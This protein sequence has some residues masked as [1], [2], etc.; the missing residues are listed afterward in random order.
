MNLSLQKPQTREVISPL[1]VECQNEAEIFKKVDDVAA[2]IKSDLN[3]TTEQIAAD[4]DRNIGEISTPNAEAWA[5]YVEARRHQ[6]RGEDIKAIPLLQKALSLDPEFIMAMRV[7]GLANLHI[8]NYPEAKRCRDRTLE[9][10]QKHPERISERD[11]Y[12]FEAGYYFGAGPEPEWGKSLDAGRK[13][14]AL[15]PDDLTGST[16]L[17]IVYAQVED[18]ENAL[19]CF[20]QSVRGRSRFFGTYGGMAIA[21]RAIGEPA[22]GQEVLERYLREVENTAVGH[23]R[24]AYHHITQNRLDLAGRELE[25]AET[26][27]PD[28]YESREFRGDLFLLR[29]DAPQAEAEYRALIAEKAPDAHYIGYDGLVIG[30]LF[31]GRYEEIIK[32]MAPLAEEFKRAGDA[33]AERF[34]HGAIAY[35]SLRSGRPEVAVAEC[36]KAYKIDV[37]NYDFDSKRGALLLKGVAYLAL[38]RIA[39]A[40][41]TAG[42]LKALIDKGLKKK[43]MRLYDHL[44]GAIE[45][46]RNNAPKAL[47]YLERSVR[48][49]PYGPFEKDAGFINM[50]AEAYVRAGDLPRARE[51]YERIGMLTT[52][53]LGSGD[54]YARQFGMYTTVCLGSSD[55]YARSFYHIGLIDE[56]LGDRAGVRVNYQKFL[57]LWKGAD[58]G[59]PELEDAK[60]RL[61]SL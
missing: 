49:L 19:K 36:D 8:A 14:L 3:V 30:L 12:V 50:L 42:E 55:V 40:E 15:Y 9:L 16:N 46:E 43:E 26:L 5:Y 11:R 24:L 38:K 58:P 29:G 31:E 28:D 33:R 41:R 13:L 22:K 44:M 34:C 20:E 45:I 61:A 18:W 4:I 2:R 7:L 57:D 32:I 27:A 53:R 23:L 21:C 59:L 6:L 60:K 47:E 10:V 39:E 51:Q 25:T 37:G 17:G 35:S 56:K 48:S 1:D 54:V 52:G